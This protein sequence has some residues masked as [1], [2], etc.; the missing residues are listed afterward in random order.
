GWGWNDVI[1]WISFNC[2]QTSHGG[3]DNCSDSSYG[4][5]VN[6]NTGD[7]SGYAWN[8]VDGWI[9]FNCSNNGGCGT[10]DY[11]LNTTWR[12]TSTTGYV[13]SSTFDTTVSSGATLNSLMWEGDSPGGTCVKFQIAASNNSSGPWNFKGPSGDNATYYGAS[14]SQKITGQDI[15]STKN[16]PICVDSSQFN[17]YRYYRYKAFIISNL[18]QTL[19]PRID[20]VLLN[21]SK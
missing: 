5:T 13:I 15:C 20:D 7:F 9:S 12:A 8:D 3:S 21:F 18:A 11:K 16:T 10:N 19:T 14:C 2:D 4:V 17:N 6:Q 1:G